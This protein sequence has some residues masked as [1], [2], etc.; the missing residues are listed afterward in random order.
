MCRI[1]YEKLYITVNKV[2]HSKFDI[3]SS[4]RNLPGEDHVHEWPDNY[5]E[6]WSSLLLR[7]LATLR[8][9]GRSQ[10]IQLSGL[11]VAV[12]IL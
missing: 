5:D 3:Y 11:R 12:S 4:V 7:L 6:L 1:V 8:A 2:L 9:D 10:G